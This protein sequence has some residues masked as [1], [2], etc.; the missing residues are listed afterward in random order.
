MTFVADTVLFVP[1]TETDIIHPI[2]R[3]SEYTPDN[4][5][6]AFTDDGLLLGRTPLIER[7][8]G[9]FFVRE[10]SDIARLVKYSFPNEVAVDRLMP[11]LARVALALN[12]NDQAAAR[13]AAVHLQIPDLPSST[14][15]NALVAEDALI[16]YARDQGGDSDWNPALHPRAGVPP[17]P[18]WFAPTGGPQHESSQ[19]ESSHGGSRLRFAEN[20]DHSRRTDAVPPH[21]DWVTLPPGEYN[22]ELADFIQWLANAKPE[23]A[24]TIRAEIKRYYYDAAMRMAGTR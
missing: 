6:L 14:A 15:R 3:L 9:H 8:D 2:W 11:G 21:D 19:D 10:P 5:G 23:D 18:G 4:L 17:N 20:E 16:K 7:R 1:I 12:A 24:R 22:D 13:I